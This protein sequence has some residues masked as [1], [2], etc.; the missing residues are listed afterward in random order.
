MPQ[1][2]GW[3]FAKQNSQAQRYALSR[4][5]PLDCFGATRLE[6]TAAQG[7]GGGA[8][9]ATPQ[10]GP[11]RGNRRLPWRSPGKPDPAAG[12]DAPKNDFLCACK[13][14]SSL[15]NRHYLIEGKTRLLSRLE[16]FTDNDTAIAVCVV[17]TG[18][19]G[20][21]DVMGLL[22]ACLF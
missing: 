14:Q 20:W 3:S 22:A 6:M 9:R 13:L 1:L 21:E 11:E 15:V 7:I 18:L 19:A 8:K 12:G 10:A 16:H 17:Q 2:S 4:P 5:L